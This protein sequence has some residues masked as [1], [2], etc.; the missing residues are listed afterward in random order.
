MQEIEPVMDYAISQLCMSV[1]LHAKTATVHHVQ[2]VQQ[3][4]FLNQ[5]ANVEQV[6]GMVTL[7]RILFAERVM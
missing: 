7:F 3:I 4:K 6:V 2:S 1:I 5:M